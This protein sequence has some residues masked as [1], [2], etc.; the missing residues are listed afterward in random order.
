MLESAEAE[1]GFVTQGGFD[2]EF[3]TPA[4]EFPG[5]TRYL[6]S[7]SAATTFTAPPG[8]GDGGRPRDQGGHDQRG[9]ET[10]GPGAPRGA[11][12]RRGTRA[13]E[14]AMSQGDERC[15]ECGRPG[16][17]RRDCPR[18]AAM[19]PPRG[20]RGRPE[21][22]GHGDGCYTCGSLDHLRRNCPLTATQRGDGGGRGR[23]GGRGGAGGHQGSGRGMGPSR[24]GDGGGPGDGRVAPGAG[25]CGY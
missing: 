14:T 7:G 17:F 12:A 13:R 25:G 19:A 20:H 15:H 21:D 4:G 5:T 23:G 16:H 11:K 10:T 9:P 1:Q 2:G 8:F 18:L 3:V 6:D 22:D 24:R